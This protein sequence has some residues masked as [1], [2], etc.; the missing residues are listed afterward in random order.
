MPSGALR[1]PEEPQG[2]YTLRK[3]S[4]S[5]M[6]EKENFTIFFTSGTIDQ[7]S[8]GIPVTGTHTALKLP[9]KYGLNNTQSSTECEV[10]YFL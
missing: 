1:R 5:L 9:W 7:R 3:M 10:L 8:E 2:F 4:A 6:Q